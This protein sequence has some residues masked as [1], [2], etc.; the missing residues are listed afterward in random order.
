MITWRPLKYTS[1]E[2]RKKSENYFDFCEE[3]NKPK[4]L[5][6]L[7]LYLW[8]YKDFISE[9]IKDTNFSETISYIRLVTENDI[10]EWI[11]TKKYHHRAWEFNLKN[12]YWWKDRI[13][14]V[15]SIDIDVI[16]LENKSPDELLRLLEQINS[17]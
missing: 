10:E 1:T 3:T 16:K 9:K 2:M 14:N 6:W 15:N 12:N 13:D 17:N 7:C 4:T 5:S 11:L 8:V